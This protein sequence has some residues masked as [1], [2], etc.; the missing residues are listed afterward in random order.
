MLTTEN[1]ST[2]SQER[3]PRLYSVVN[4]LVR[5]VYISVVCLEP[6]ETSISLSIFSLIFHLQFSLV[7][8]AFAHLIPGGQIFNTLPSD[9]SIPALCP[10][11]LMGVSFIHE[12]NYTAIP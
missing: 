3:T 7:L 10:L 6:S 2:L 11:L 1:L 9:T 4:R 12:L 8:L 5:L